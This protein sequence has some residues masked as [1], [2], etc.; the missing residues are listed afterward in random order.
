MDG[1]FAL[2]LGCKAVFAVMLIYFCYA[3]C[4]PILAILKRNGP[5]PPR[6]KPSAYLRV[7]FPGACLFSAAFGPAL[8]RTG[9]VS[10]F[11]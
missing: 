6:P 5:V 10:F 3:L 1:R 8:T 2:I 7:S 4:I 9:Q 11:S